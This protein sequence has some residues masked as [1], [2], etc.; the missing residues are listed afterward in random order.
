[1]PT[2]SP[3]FRP[4]AAAIWVE[5][6]FW[7]PSPVTSAT[8]AVAGAGDWVCA[9]ICLE[10][11]KATARQK[12]IAAIF[13]RIRMERVFMPCMGFIVTEDAF[14]G[15]WDG[16]VFGSVAEETNKVISR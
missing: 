5:F 16:C 2:E 9:A 1:L 15:W 13:E 14:D 4:L 7:E 11:E 12:I 8:L 10:A 6:I 3:G